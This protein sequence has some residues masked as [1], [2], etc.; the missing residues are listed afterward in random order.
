MYKYVESIVTQDPL[1]S[2]ADMNKMRAKISESEATRFETYYEINES[3]DMHS[4]YSKRLNEDLI[5]EHYQTAFT[6]MR[7]SS[8]RL[9]VKTER[10]ININ[11]NLR[12]CK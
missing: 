11:R 8:P 10:W 9:R 3:L 7:T 4:V 2:E 5:P 12:L 1:A 6:R